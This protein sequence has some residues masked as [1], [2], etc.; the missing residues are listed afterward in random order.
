MISPEELKQMNEAANKAID[1]LV[2]EYNLAIEN[3][4]KEQV[5]EVVRQLFASGD[6]VRLV[7]CSGQYRQSVVYL[8]Y[9]EQQRLQAHINRL[10]AVLKQNG[11]SLEKESD[12][13]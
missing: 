8:P 11:W 12:A 13:T 3:L 7:S 6:I 9:S 1:N 4:T 10:E 5:S 2:R